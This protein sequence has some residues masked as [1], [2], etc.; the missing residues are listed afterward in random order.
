ML[1]RARPLNDSFTAHCHHSLSTLSNA[2]RG[3]EVLVD[4]EAMVL[5]LI[6]DECEKRSSD[7]WSLETLWCYR[8]LLEG[9]GFEVKSVI[10]RDRSVQH[11]L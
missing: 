6:R 10:R 3:E 1:L 7:K 8:F 5:G 11:T 9:A 4:T 2:P